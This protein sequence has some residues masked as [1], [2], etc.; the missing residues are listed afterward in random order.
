M[1]KRNL[2]Y[3]C[4]CIIIYLLMC[5]A[6]FLLGYSQLGALCSLHL[7][8]PLAISAVPTT[9]YVEGYHNHS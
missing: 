2:L 6:T 4:E 9:E 1:G 3:L 7:L 5:R 8:K